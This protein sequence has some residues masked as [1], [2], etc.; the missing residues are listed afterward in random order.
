MRTNSRPPP[1]CEPI[2]KR[3]PWHPGVA[4]YLIHMYDYPPI[5]QKGVDAAKRFA[6]SPRMRRMP[7]T[8]RRISLPGWAT[9]RSRSFRITAARIARANNEADDQL[10]A[11]DYMVYAYLQMGQDQKAREICDEMSAVTGF[12]PNRNTGPFALAASPARYAMERGDWSAAAELKVRPSKFAYVEAITYF[13]RALGA[14]RSGN[15]QPA[16]VDIAKFGRAS[17]QAARSEG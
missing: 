5:A 3:Q 10:H 13:A 11:S 17:R 7:S 4:H 8:C 14:A 15:P 16:K 6:E 12:D 1:S 9:G 2:F